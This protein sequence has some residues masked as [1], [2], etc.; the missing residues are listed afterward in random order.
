LYT[1]SSSGGRTQIVRIYMHFLRPG[2]GGGGRG[3]HAAAFLLYTFAFTSCQ[4]FC[5]HMVD[6]WHL[7]VMELDPFCSNCHAASLAAVMSCTVV[8]SVR[9]IYLSCS[10]VSGP[11]VMQHYKS[12]ISSCIVALPVMQL[13]RSCSLFCHACRSTCHEA[14]F[15]CTCHA[16]SAPFH[17][18]LR[19]FVMQIHLSYNSICH[20]A[21]SVVQVRMNPGLYHNVCRLYCKLWSTFKRFCQWGLLFIIYGSTFIVYH[22]FSS[23]LCFFK[24][25][26]RSFE[27]C[28]EYWPGVNNINK[29]Q[30]IIDLVLLCQTRTA[31]IVDV[32][33]VNIVTWSGGVWKGGRS[34]KGW[35]VVSK[36]GTRVDG[37]SR[38]QQES[39]FST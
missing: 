27:N 32:V 23:S 18:S 12:C 38:Q 28:K 39:W 9:Q 29:K 5:V 3:G 30:K 15:S 24:I 13:R 2:P 34:S 10:R 20:A 4:I 31:D 16:I 25:E 33:Y 7:N 26:P 8:L 1:S 37:Y 11:L 17:M 22:S 21:S 36:P 19:S 6:N 14:A 35:A